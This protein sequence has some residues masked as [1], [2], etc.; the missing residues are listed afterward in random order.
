MNKN[1]LRIQIGE[2]VIGLKFNIGTLKA[3]GELAGVDP[4]QFKAASGEFKDIAPFGKV[5]FHA[6]IISNYRGQK[7]EIDF[8]DQDVDLWYDELTSDDVLSIIKCY[9]EP[10]SSAPS[11]NGE[12]GKDTQFAAIL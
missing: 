4:F 10:G 2:K 3:V 8:T 7:K 12:G 6:A 11:V 1:Y 9:N 5:I